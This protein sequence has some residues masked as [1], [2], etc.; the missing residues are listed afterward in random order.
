[1]NWELET[2]LVMDG[3]VHEVGGGLWWKIEAR[4]VSP[5]PERPHGIKYSL[6]LHDGNNQR[7]F[8]ID[9][10]HGLEKQSRSTGKKRRIEFD[11]QHEGQ[12][13]IAYEYRSAPDLLLDFFEAVDRERRKRNIT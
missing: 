13:V 7:L 4:K 12:T 11:H 2:L 10:A 5:T 8:G 3:E 9:N 6:T 1:M